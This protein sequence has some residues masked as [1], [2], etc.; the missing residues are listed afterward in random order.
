MR[1]G[2]KIAI[3]SL[4]PP[5][6]AFVTARYRSSTTLW[7][8]NPESDVRACSVDGSAFHVRARS[9]LYAQS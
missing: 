4:H 6:P 3:A 9:M 1:Q 7:G 5:S 8:S 2:T